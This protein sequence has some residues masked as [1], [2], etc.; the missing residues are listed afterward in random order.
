LLNTSHFALEEESELIG[1][2]ISNFLNN[3]RRTS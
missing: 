3:K 2:L 1:S